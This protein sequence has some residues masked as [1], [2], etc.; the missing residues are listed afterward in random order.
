MLAGSKSD[1]PVLTTWLSATQQECSAST[2]NTQLLHTDRQRALLGYNRTMARSQSQ[3]EADRGRIAESGAAE[4]GEEA[5]SAP[6]SDDLSD[7][8]AGRF[9]LPLSPVDPSRCSLWHS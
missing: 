4:S 9:M 6:K 3:R 7:G 5:S 8:Y 2:H 1:A